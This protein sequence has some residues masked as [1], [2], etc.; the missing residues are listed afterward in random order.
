VLHEVFIVPNSGSNIHGNVFTQEG[1]N[2]ETL[3]KI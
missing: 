2:S 1:A 3:C